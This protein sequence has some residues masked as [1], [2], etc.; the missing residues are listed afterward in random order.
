MVVF[1]QNRSFFKNFNSQIFKKDFP[2]TIL[3]SLVFLI[4]PHKIPSVKLNRILI[5]ILTIILLLVPFGPAPRKTDAASYYIGG[6]PVPGPLPPSFYAPLPP[7]NVRLNLNYAG[8]ANRWQ[9]LDFAKPVMCASQKVPVIAYVH[10]GWWLGGSKTGAI[11]SMPARLA[12]QLG[13]AVVS[14]EYRLASSTNHPQT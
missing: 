1:C 6:R 14:I 3:L 9:T 4:K 7:L 8:S 13:F 11:Y 10:G 5:I 12:Y 2:K